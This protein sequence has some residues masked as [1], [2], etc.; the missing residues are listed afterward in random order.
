MG[1]YFFRSPFGFYPFP[2][3]YRPPYGYYSNN[4]YQEHKYEPNKAEKNHT[5][6]N[7]PDENKCN[8]S[9]SIYYDKPIF[10]FFGIK[11]FFDDI[12]II[13]LIFFL[14]NEGVKD[15]N[16]FIALILLLLS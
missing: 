2:R 12:L 16:L 10:E 1:P 15:Q 9:D 6:K 5:E 7:K 14:Y 8:S 4:Q 13:S 11:L 3:F